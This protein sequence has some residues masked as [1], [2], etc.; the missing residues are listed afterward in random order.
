MRKVRVMTAGLA[1]ATLLAGCGGG[2]D[3]SGKDDASTAPKSSATS[4]P[5][6]AESPEDETSTAT[7]NQYASIV[8]RSS[9]LRDQLDT[10][11]DCDWI[12]TGSLDYDTALFTCRIGSLTLSLQAG[13]LNVSLTTAQNPDRPGYLGEPPTELVDLIA[14]TQSAAAEVEDAFEQIDSKDCGDTGKGACGDIR[15][16]AFRSIGPLQSALRA[17]DP[18]L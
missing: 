12:G 3:D 9:D 6:S 14:E 18:Y 13:T 4:Q 8:A 7:P 10:M 5:T 2:D 15:G 1:A 16:R 17:W 11:E